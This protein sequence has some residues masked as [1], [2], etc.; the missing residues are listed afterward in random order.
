MFAA[1]ARNSS[2]SCVRADG[3]VLVVQETAP[4]PL[5][6]GWMSFLDTTFMI[7][8]SSILFYPLFQVYFGSRYAPREYI[9]RWYRKWLK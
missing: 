9:K 6:D 8:N 5:S 7:M 2:L 1:C 4:R 3:L